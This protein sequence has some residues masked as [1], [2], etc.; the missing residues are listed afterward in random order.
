M[1][2]PITSEGDETVD[3]MELLHDPPTIALPTGSFPILL[4]A[5]HHVAV[6]RRPLSVSTPRLPV[7]FLGGAKEKKSRHLPDA[8]D[9]ER[10]PV[11]HHDA[12]SVKGI[13]DHGL[14]D[15]SELGDHSNRQVSAGRKPLEV[16][17]AP[18]AEQGRKRPSALALMD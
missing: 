7:P 1:I 16:G 8:S 4:A 18:H 11:L 6:P 17:P 9:A 10:A 2:D 15:R 3:G 13:K 14:A 12:G 5:P